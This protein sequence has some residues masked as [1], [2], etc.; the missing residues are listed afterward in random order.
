MKKYKTVQTG[1]KIQLGG[2]NDG[3]LRLTYQLFIEG[4]VTKAPKTPIACV[5]I[6]EQANN[7]GFFIFSKVKSQ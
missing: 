3:L 2:L 7:T 4:V 1:P 6:I 5:R